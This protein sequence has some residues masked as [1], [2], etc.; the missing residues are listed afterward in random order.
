MIVDTNDLLVTELPRDDSQT[1]TFNFKRAIIIDHHLEREISDLRVVAKLIL[2]NHESNVEI[3]TEFF[4]KMSFSPDPAIA[5]I[6]IMGILTD[7][8]YFRYGN[9]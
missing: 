9:N 1:I 3:I 2:S 7:T 8:G 4:R 5:K 6:M